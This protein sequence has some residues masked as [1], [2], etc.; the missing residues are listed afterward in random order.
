MTRR[1]YTGP[2]KA[3]NKKRHEGEKAMLPPPTPTG[4][5]QNTGH[6]NADGD[7]HEE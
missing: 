3:S 5:E 6:N 2:A 7:A 1:H 4:V